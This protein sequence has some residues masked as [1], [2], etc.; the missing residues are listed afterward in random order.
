MEQVH[1]KVKEYY[2]LQAERAPHLQDT[3]EG[4]AGAG[5]GTSNATEALPATGPARL[6]VLRLR[7]GAAVNASGNS[8]HQQQPNQKQ[9]RDDGR[10]DDSAVRALKGAVEEKTAQEGKK[11]WL[12]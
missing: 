12:W 4:A 5:N 7:G 3:P 10:R 1:H 9:G 6:R 2:K 11:G 8:R